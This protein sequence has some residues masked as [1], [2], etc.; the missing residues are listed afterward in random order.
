MHTAARSL[1]AVRK[2]VP[3]STRGGVDELP[4][5]PNLAAYETFVCQRGVVMFSCRECRGLGLGLGSSWCDE[6]DECGDV[7]TVCGGSR[8][9]SVWYL[10]GSKLSK[11]S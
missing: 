10:I 4:S 11:P 6:C 1:F 5:V 8:G 2:T 9:Y 3:T 7:L